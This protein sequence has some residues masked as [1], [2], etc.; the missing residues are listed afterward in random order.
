MKTVNLKNDSD[1]SCCEPMPM[2]N[3]GYGL[4]LYLNSDTCEKLGITKPIKAGARVEVR[5]S[6]IVVQS[7]ETVDNDESPTDVSL[8]LQI[9]DMGLEAGAVVRDAAK[10]L[11]G[12][13]D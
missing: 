5:A 11:Y 7:S 4:R 9:T 1:E 12:S 13:S 2:N 10:L 3:Y 8:S 6:A